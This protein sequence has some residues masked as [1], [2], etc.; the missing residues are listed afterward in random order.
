MWMASMMDKESVRAYWNEGTFVNR[1]QG[2]EIQSLLKEVTHL[3][4]HGIR[5]RV[6]RECITLPQME[7][8]QVL[9]RQGPLTVNQLSQALRLTNGTVSDML[10]RMEDQELVERVRD[11]HD[12][13]VVHVALTAKFNALHQELGER[14]DDYVGDLFSEISGDDMNTI[15]TGL[16]TL[17]LALSRDGR[18]GHMGGNHHEDTETIR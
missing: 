8:V 11:K 18:P 9:R 4:G 6:C 3:M 17:R 2:E 12:R 16:H 15:L 5:N 14:M 1:Q 10:G 7:L 13:R